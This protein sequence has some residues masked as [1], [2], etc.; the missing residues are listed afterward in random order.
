MPVRPSTPSQDVTAPPEI[1]APLS[2]TQIKEL[3]V[4]IEETHLKI[5]ETIRARKILEN[6][7]VDLRQKVRNAQRGPSDGLAGTSS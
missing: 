2:P 1:P 3:E 5:T 6:Q 4:E 7:I